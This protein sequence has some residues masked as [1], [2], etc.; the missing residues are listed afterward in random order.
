MNDRLSRRQMLHLSA[1]A[2]LSLGLWP[3]ALRAEGKGAGGNFDFVVINDIHYINEKCAA[4]LDR[5]MKQIK[6]GPAPDFAL[7]AGDLSHHGTQQEFGAVKEILAQLG[8]P[9]FVL[10]GNHDYVTQTDRKQYEQAHP[11]QLNYAFEHKGWQFVGFDS[12]EGLRAANTKIQSGPVEFLTRTAGKISKT[13]PAVLFTHFPLGE[14][15]DKRPLNA[16]SVLELFKGHNLQAAFGGHH[17][18][19]TERTFHDATLVT[20]RCCSFSQPN[21]DGTKEKGFFACSAK[22]G[23]ISR[24]FVEVSTANI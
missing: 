23:R 12:T 5:V 15:V 13:Q 17:H 9:I 11:N 8:I 4:F 3:G 24:S 20:N 22:D 18:G 21:H 1:G 19:F 7:I 10:P 14:K 2:L 6:T 16:E